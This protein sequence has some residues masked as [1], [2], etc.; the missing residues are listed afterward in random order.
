MGNVK[1]DAVE[2]GGDRAPGGILVA[3]QN[4]L[5]LV[6]FEFFGRRAAGNFAGRHLARRQHVGIVFVGIARRV[7]LQERRRRTQTKMQKLDRERAAVPFHRPRHIGEPFELRV[8]PQAG[9]AERRID[10]IFIDEVPAENDHSEP[11]LGALLVIGD[12]LLGEDTLVRASDPGRAHRSE[13][14]PVRQGRIADAKRRQQM[15]IGL[16]IG[17]GRFPSNV[18][19]SG[20][21]RAC[22]AG[23]CTGLAVAAVNNRPSEGCNP[24]LTGA[25]RLAK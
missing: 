19:C 12:R 10:G 13:Y 14:H 3:L 15:A 8:V 5:D 9:K 21:K 6:L 17:H 4:V 16:G 24:L 22:R 11:G 23:R 1:F 2:A 20:N 25:S 7:G 18:F